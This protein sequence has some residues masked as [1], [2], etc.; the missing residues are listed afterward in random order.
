M[1]RHLLRLFSSLI[2]T[3]HGQSVYRWVNVL[4]T[5]G[6][7]FDDVNGRY[8]TI[9]KPPTEL[10]GGAAEQ[11]TTDRLEGGVQSGWHQEFKVNKLR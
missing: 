7:G 9:A 3:E 4:D 11:L 10:S 1:V 8:L 2:E 6:D 5:R